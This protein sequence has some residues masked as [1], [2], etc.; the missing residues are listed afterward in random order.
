MI[1]AKTNVVEAKTNVVEAKTNVV[2]A[3]T[4]VVEAKTNV[5]EAK[6]NVVEAK[7]NVVEAKTNVIEAKNTSPVA[8]L[9]H[10]L[11]AKSA[12]IQCM[13]SQKNQQN[14]VGSEKNNAYCTVLKRSTDCFSLR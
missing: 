7:T 14:W 6:T 9:S 3:K 8:A 12:R 4:N 10:L 5:V 1:E 2:E 13:F 11:T